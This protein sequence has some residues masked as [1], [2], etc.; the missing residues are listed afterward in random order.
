MLGFDKHGLLDKVATKGTPCIKV[1][2]DI[3]VTEVPGQE[4]AEGNV[5]GRKT[6]RSK[7]AKL[8]NLLKSK[9]HRSKISPEGS[10]IA[11]DH[12]VEDF[13]EKVHLDIKVGADI[14]VTGVPGQ[15][16]PEGN[17]A[18]RKKRWSKK[19]KLGN[20]LKYKA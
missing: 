18:G 20:L 7:E 9:T 14:T 16:G 8:R 11:G 15:E 19:A 13:Q 12:E 1:K 3:T 5:A 10:S 17:V 2:S 6:R 4:G